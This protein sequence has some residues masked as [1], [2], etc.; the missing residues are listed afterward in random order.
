MV[1]SYQTMKN[2]LSRTDVNIYSVINLCTLIL[3]SSG[4]HAAPT[5]SLVQVSSDHLYVEIS[6][7]VGSPFLPV[8]PFSLLLAQPVIV[9]P[10]FIHNFSKH[11]FTSQKFFEQGFL[12]KKFLTGSKCS[13]CLSQ[14][15]VRIMVRSIAIWRNV[16]VNMPIHMPCKVKLNIP[17]RNEYKHI[18]LQVIKQHCS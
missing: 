6:S 18:L 8:P 14:F 5:F 17:Q 16:P 12:K 4:C 15:V 7:V 10:S 3:R 13:T 1:S 9:T 2:I 11:T